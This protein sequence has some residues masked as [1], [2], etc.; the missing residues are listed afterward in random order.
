MEIFERL[1]WYGIFGVLSLYMTAPT[2]L[3]GLGV[4]DQQRGTLSAVVMSFI[5]LLPVITGALGD[6]YGYRR[7]LL[8]SF[9]LMTPSYYLLGQVDSYGTFF[10]IYMVLA[11][12]AAIFKPLIVGTVS[13]ETTDENRSLGF[14]LF[15]TMVNIGGFLGPLTVAYLREISWD[16]AF[17]MAAA[18]IAINFIPA[19]F[20]FKDPAKESDSPKNNKSIKKILIEVQDVLGNGRLA[21]LVVPIMILLLIPGTG[22]LEWKDVGIICF[23][24]LF[25]N[26]IWDKISKKQNYNWY[27]SKIKLGNVPFILYL[28]ILAGFWAVYIQIFVSLNIFIRDYIN[29]SDLI[30]FFN[31]ID[32]IMS[33]F[34]SGANVEKL[35]P[36]IQQLNLAHTENVTPEIIQQVYFKLTNYSV[37]IPAN[38]ISQLLNLDQSY[39][40]IN[41]ANII[42]NEWISKY[43][44]VKPEIIASINF[45]SIVILQLFFSKFS[46]KFKIFHVLIG[47]TLLL[48]LSYL[49]LAVAPSLLISGTAV[50]A[51]VLLFSIGEMLVSPKSMEYIAM[52]MPK[53]KSAM[54]QGYLYLASAFGFLAGGLLSGVGYEYFAKTL[55]KP[56][57]FW[58]MFSIIGVISALALLVYDKYFSNKLESQKQT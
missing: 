36:L 40:D 4:S 42:S 14:G 9:A 10:L 27:S 2:D 6:R 32:P 19:I 16:L 56:G 35:V 48:S 17:T 5:Y 43:Q 46:A 7:M 29:T 24:W 55:N 37:M 41:K 21:L 39:L 18:A 51:A 47:G 53:E 58:Y 49:L 31:S 38:E 50:V 26:F 28:L 12:G 25:I 44:Q 57:Y 52:V 11:V 22:L 23:L 45:G 30:T 15:Y 8:I 34:I 20:L 54:Y 33:N 1:A 3:G 13:R